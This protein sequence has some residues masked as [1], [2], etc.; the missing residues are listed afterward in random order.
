MRAIQTLVT[1]SLLLAPVAALAQER[2]DSAAF[3]VRLGHDTT[4]IERVVRTRTQVVAEAVQ[5]SPATMLHRMVMELTPRGEVSRS[6]YT[7]T[8]PGSAEPFFT[9]TITIAGDSATVTNAQG[10]NTRTRRVAA[11][12]AIPIS[13]PFYSPYETAMMRAVAGR[14]PRAT[15]QL[16]Q[17]D[18]T[19]NIPLERVGADSLALTNQFQERMRARIDERGRLLNLHTPAFTTVERVAW[20]NL[21]PWVREFAA[22]DAAG[23]GMGP[24]S[25]RQ[26]S[27]AFTG[28]ANLWLDYSR[29]GMRGRPIWGALVPYGAVWR[30]GANDAAHFA[31]DRPV[32]LGD[33]ALQPGTYTLFLLPTADAWTL[34]VNRKTGISGLEHDPRM[35]VGRVAM[36]RQALERPVEQFTMELRPAANGAT[37]YAAWDREAATIPIRIEP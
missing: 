3:V 34:V 26:A 27:R 31:T 19:V 9:R 32:R 23:R 14:Q 1:A 5:R 2:A 6:V 24:L 37:L 17:P 10:T 15:V 12:N 8:R 25:P 35:D 4:S 7:A 20:L 13:G 11:R 36:T 16:L 29:P 28:G 21:E 33:L 22:R 18:T 30:M